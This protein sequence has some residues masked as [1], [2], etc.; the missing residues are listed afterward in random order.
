[1]LRGRKH[2]LGGRTLLH[3]IDFNR[4]RHVEA[5]LRVHLD[6][7]FSPGQAGL[8]YM[9]SHLHY[10]QPGQSRLGTP[11]SDLREASYLQQ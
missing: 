5:V 1:M 2:C 3:M 7:E 6:A 10:H 8:S 9:R 11:V 4:V